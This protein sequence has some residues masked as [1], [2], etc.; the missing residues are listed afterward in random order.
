MGLVPWSPDL[1]PLDYFLWG[2]MKSMV[3]G[4]PVTSEED[5]EQGFRLE[6]ESACHPEQHTK[7]CLF[8]DPLY[9]A[10]LIVRQQ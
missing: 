1:T 10:Y 7:R 5:R 3:Y 6:K 9:T 4:N 2:N 8:L